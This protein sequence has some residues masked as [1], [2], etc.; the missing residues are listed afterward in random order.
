MKGAKAR[1]IAPGA[2]RAQEAADRFVGEQPHPGR[3][4]KTHNLASIKASVAKFSKFEDR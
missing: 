2:A 4:E 3:C 1:R